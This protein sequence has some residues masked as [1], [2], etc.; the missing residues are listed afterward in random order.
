MAS[1][2]LITNQWERNYENLHP[3]H[4]EYCQGLDEA[5][6]ALDKSLRA[7]AIPGGNIE[8]KRELNHI[9]YIISTYKDRAIEEVKI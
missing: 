1:D 3:I 5:M 2:N 7:A 6:D 8:V 4:K 9:K